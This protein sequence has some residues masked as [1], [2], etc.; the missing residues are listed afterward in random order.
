[1]SG[2]LRQC[3]FTATPSLRVAAAR[4]VHIVFLPQLASSKPL[5]TEATFLTA[6]FAGAACCAAGAAFVAGL[7]A[8]SGAF[9]A[10]AL[11]LNTARV[12]PAT[13]ASAPKRFVRITATPPCAEA[14]ACMT[15]AA[16]AAI[17]AAAQPYIDL[18]LQIMAD[19]RRDEIFCFC[20]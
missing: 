7:A 16:I 17:V 6:A 14:V 2:F 20:F 12:R 3:A 13:S 1:M 15:S 5:Q 11:G 9:W 8:A 18:Q 10:M 19:I 4:Q